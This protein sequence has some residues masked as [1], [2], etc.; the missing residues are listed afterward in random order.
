MIDN[1]PCV[2]INQLAVLHLI[3]RV[4]E[5]YMC[6]M[7]PYLIPTNKDEPKNIYKHGCIVWR[8]ILKCQIDFELVH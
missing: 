6:A 4:A 3:Y 7:T 5:E 1:L 8:H 2:L